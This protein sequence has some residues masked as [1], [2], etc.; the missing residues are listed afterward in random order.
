MRLPDHPVRGR[1]GRVVFQRG[2]APNPEELARLTAARQRARLTAWS[3]IRDVEVI[4]LEGN[5]PERV[6]LAW[7]LEGPDPSGADPTGLAE[8]VSRIARAL[9]G[10]KVLVDD[11]LALFSRHGAR[12][13]AS[14]SRG[15]RPDRLPTGWQPRAG[16]TRG[17]LL[18]FLGVLDVSSS[19]DF[20]VVALSAGPALHPRFNFRHTIQKGVLSAAGLRA[21]A[22][23][24]EANIIP[25][26][27][28]PE[29][30]LQRL[31]DGDYRERCAA[32]DL[33]TTVEEAPTPPPKAGRPRL[34]QLGAAIRQAWESAASANGLRRAFGTSDALGGHSRASTALRRVLVPLSEPHPDEPWPGRPSERELPYLTRSERFDQV[35]R[36]E[37]SDR[38]TGALALAAVGGPPMGLPPGCFDAVVAI[39]EAPASS[40]LD[41]SLAA[42]VLSRSSAPEAARRLARVAA[43]SPNSD[44]A[45]AAAEGLGGQTGPIARE[46]LRDALALPKV[47]AVAAE[48]ASRIGDVGALQNILALAESHDETHRT[49]AARALARIGAGPDVIETLDRLSEDP[50]PR[51]GRAA[52]ASRA[53]HRSPTELR[54]WVQTAPATDLSA[55]LD[56]LGRRDRTDA[57]PVL[58]R[59][60]RHPAPDVRAAAAAALGWFELPGATPLLLSALN[61]KDPHVVVSVCAALARC[62]DNRAV[63]ALRRMAAGTE[64]VHRAAARALRAGRHLRSM[65]PD[66]KIHLRALAPSPLPLTLAGRLTSALQGPEL[67]C[68]VSAAGIN[69]EATVSPDDIPGLLRIT[70]M[71]ERAA[72]VCPDLRWSVRDGQHAIR[73]HGRR[74]TVSRR[75]GRVVRDAGWFEEPAHP[76]PARPP[77]VPLEDDSDLLLDEQGFGDDLI[78]DDSLS[79][80]PPL[81]PGEDIGDDLVLEDDIDLGELLVPEAPAPVGL[82]GLT[83]GARPEATDPAPSSS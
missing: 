21:L 75:R 62:A 68:R 51:T 32:R 7:M 83:T 53:V 35:L 18:D 47:A 81:D 72:E 36:A 71:L 76:T 25:P 65:P 46:A 49:A 24:A 74:W 60:L 80:D 40:S 82:A 17:Q 12:Y 13:L 27:G 64:T 6:M 23:L 48:A 61:D 3:H 5:A 10:A 66:D 70:S 1:R 37:A 79:L 33:L 78:L 9:P 4:L 57:W 20:D 43:E 2:R 69:G 14:P 28:L 26:T 38:R 44:V 67:R 15:T 30:A 29:L 31:E 59:G 11:P 52:R 55:A 22:A 54:A 77:L 34:A 45:S 63:P 16:T 39:L 56:L 8:L 50:S 41:A 58:V 19:H 42:I 73:R